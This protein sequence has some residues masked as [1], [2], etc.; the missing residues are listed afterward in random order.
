MKSYWFAVVLTVVML[1]CCVSCK[2]ERKPDGMPDL[3]PCTVKLTQEGQ[4][5]EGA[6]ILCQSDDAQLIRWAVTGQTGADG[7]AK[8]FTMGKFAGAPAG[9]F[10]VVVTKEESEGGS[11][12]SEDDMTE[13]KSGGFGGDVYSLVSLDQTAKETTPHKITVEAGGKNAFEFDCGEKVRVKRP[14]DPF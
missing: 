8:I 4:P 10:A 11:A 1:T 7:V 13:M 5:L 9:T 14:R 2:E 3:Y 12:P 6:F